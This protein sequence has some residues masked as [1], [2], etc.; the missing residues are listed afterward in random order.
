MN[1]LPCF[2][3]RLLR[4]QLPRSW[5]PAGVY[6]G[7]I[8]PDNGRDQSWAVPVIVAVL[9]IA[10]VTLLLMTALIDPGFVP[11]NNDPRDAE[12]G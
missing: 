6:F 4:L 12:L 8:A 10:A 3:P 1:V 5:L 9:L 2:P 7:F 11:R